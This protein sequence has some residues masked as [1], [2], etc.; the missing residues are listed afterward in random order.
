M[1]IVVC[2]SLLGV[3]YLSCVVC[4]LLFRCFAFCLFNFAGLLL[5]RF[6]VVL[7]CLCVVYVV[8]GY[9]AVCFVWLVVGCSLLVV[10]W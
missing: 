9:V 10:G 5:C 3:G 6:V 1:L 4:S 7:F 2:C 8:C